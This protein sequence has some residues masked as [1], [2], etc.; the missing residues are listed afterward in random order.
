MFLPPILIPV[1]NSSSMAFLMMCSAYRLNK[2]G[3][4]RQ[5]VVLFSL[6]W[7][8]Q[9]FHIQGSNCYFLTCI[10]VS[11]ETGK[12]VW[13][14]HLSK[15]SP[16]F[17]IIHTVKSFSIVDERDR[18][19]FLKF[20]FYREGTKFQG[21]WAATRISLRW[22]LNQETWAQVSF[23]HPVPPITVVFA[24]WQESESCAEGR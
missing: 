11:Q 2:Q 5:H 14:S 23:H 6:S 22:E 17:V 20:S 18:C 7:T 19:F 10:Q 1:C 24:F 4:G 8:N 21:I 16:Q 12:L 9:L 13:Y 15:S 3:D